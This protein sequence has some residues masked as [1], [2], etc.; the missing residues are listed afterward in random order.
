MEEIARIRKLKI[1]TIEDHVIE[2][3]S[4][5]KNFSISTFYIE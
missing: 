1:N 3:V 5:N 2:I 4:T